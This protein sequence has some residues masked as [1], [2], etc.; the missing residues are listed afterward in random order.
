MCPIV[1]LLVGLQQLGVIPRSFPQVNACSPAASDTLKTKTVSKFSNVFRDSLTEEPMSGTPVHIH[2]KENSRPFRVS[3]ARQIPL[4]F[5]EPAARTKLFSNYWT[6]RLLLG[7][8]S[9]QI[10]VLR[11]SLLSNQM[12]KV[13]VLSRI[14]QS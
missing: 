14:T 10:G 13:C 2:L 9:L 5:R 4:R 11:D 7:V 3:V 6:T 12:E 1:L 8:M